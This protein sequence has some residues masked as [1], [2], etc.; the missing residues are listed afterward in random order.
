MD[1][2]IY[3]CGI[4]IYLKKAFDTVNHTLLL[5]KL[6][7]YGVRG[8][9]NDWFFSYLDGRSQVTQ[10]GEYTSEKVINPCGVSQGSVLGPLLFLHGIYKRYS[11]FL[12]YT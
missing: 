3:S 4:F 6:C 12:R 1:K 11:E 5:K 2:G 8:I 9:A 7:H 10:I